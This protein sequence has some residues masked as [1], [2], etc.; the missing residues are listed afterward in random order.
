MGSFVIII[1][2][3]FRVIENSGWYKRCAGIETHEPEE[4]QKPIDTEK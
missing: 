4:E 3:V 2:P 1:N